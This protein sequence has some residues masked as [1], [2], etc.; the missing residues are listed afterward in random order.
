MGA[1]FKEPCFD[2]VF[3]KGTFD[4]ILVDP[5]NEAG[6]VSLNHVTKYL[7]E[8]NKVMT[9]G[10]VYILLSFLDNESTSK[11]FKAVF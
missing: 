5:F 11:Y 9:N 3:D 7:E 8:I 1:V 10:G 2:T 6:D 4:C